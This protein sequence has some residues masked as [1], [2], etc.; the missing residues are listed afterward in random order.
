[1]LLRLGHTVTEMN[2]DKLSTNGVNVFFLKKKNHF[3]L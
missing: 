2:L 3:I 1:M